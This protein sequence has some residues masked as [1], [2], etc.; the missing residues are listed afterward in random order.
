MVNMFQILLTRK[1]L[2]TDAK[3]E[4]LESMTAQRQDIQ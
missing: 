4:F 1:Y 2:D 3:I